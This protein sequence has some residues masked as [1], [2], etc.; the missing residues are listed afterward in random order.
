MSE[1]GIKEKKLNQNNMNNSQTEKINIESNILKQEFLGKK[2]LRLEKLIESNKNDH[3]KKC[4]NKSDDESNSDEDL[5]NY[6]T[7]ISGKL[8][9][10]NILSKNL[11]QLKFEVEEEN[12]NSQTKET[13]KKIQAP[14][15][16]SLTSKLLNLLP[17]PKR[18][19]KDKIL[20]FNTNK[21][22]SL[23]NL[24]LTDKFKKL[25]NPDSELR[26]GDHLEGESSYSHPQHL[27]RNNIIDV[28]VNEQVDSNWELKYISKFA[29]TDA[30]ESNSRA[31]QPS[32]IQV[33]K[34]HIKSLISTYKKN[35][36][37]SQPEQNVSKYGKVSTRNK[38]GW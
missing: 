23:S 10:K 12:K 4:E 13:K 32:N 26:E 38:Y 37:I 21:S 31:N 3:N 36:E 24:N 29:N 30:E 14:S 18:D 2:K 16:N 33:N 9:I 20:I 11:N 7:L 35:A 34:N 1:N 28:N 6:K 19:L 25:A 22:D 17:A 15:D 5:K 8:T 27:N